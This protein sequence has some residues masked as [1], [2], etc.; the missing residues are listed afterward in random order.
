MGPTHHALEDLA[1]LSGLPHLTCHIP[2]YEDD[3][4]GRL[5]EIWASC[6]PGYL[7]LGQGLKRRDPGP[8]RVPSCEVVRP[9]AQA[10]LTLVTLGPL[11]GEALTAVEDLPEVEVISISRIPLGPE[12]ARLLSSLEGSGRLVVAEEHVARGGVGELIAARV[13]SA[14]LRL[15]RCRLVHALGYPDQLIGNQE[16]HR[17]QSGLTAVQLRETVLECL[18]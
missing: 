12:A 17:K 9:C 4:K 7:R 11:L 18:R 10:R 13:A 16:F 2:A 15:E 6:G 8:A 5:E 1:C 14:G 3:V